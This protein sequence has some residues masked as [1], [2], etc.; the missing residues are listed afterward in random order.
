LIICIAEDRKGFQPS[1]ELLILS[2]AEHCPGLKIYVIFPQCGPGVH[3]LALRL[4]SSDVLQDAAPATYSVN[5]KPRAI[6]HLFDEGHYD[7]RCIDSDIIVT[8]DLSKALATVDPQSFV[9]T[10]KALW[11]PYGDPD[12]MRPGCGGFKVG[13]VL[14]FAL[15]TIVRIKESGLRTRSSRKSAVICA[16]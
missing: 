6:L 16:R 1:I 11:T 4:S 9:L 14:P 7:I 3:L 12:G 10:E 5:V 8:D 2:L 15:N 13:R